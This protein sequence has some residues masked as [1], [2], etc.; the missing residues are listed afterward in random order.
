M[1]DIALALTYQIILISKNFRIVYPWVLLTTFGVMNATDFLAS[2][3]FIWHW[4]FS[5][6][7]V[8]DAIKKERIAH[9]QSNLEILDGVYEVG[10]ED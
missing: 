10:G 4:S 3:V 5:I 8:N 9:R 2:V 7:H 6:K 1:I